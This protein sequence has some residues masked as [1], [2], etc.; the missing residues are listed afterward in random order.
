MAANAYV[1]D[2]RMKEWH[3]GADAEV[4]FDDHQ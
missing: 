3:G 2:Q 1:F 4:L